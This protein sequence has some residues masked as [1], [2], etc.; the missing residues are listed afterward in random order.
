MNKK[1][2]SP[3]YQQSKS[4]PSWRTLKIDRWSWIPVQELVWYTPIRDGSC[5]PVLVQLVPWSR[6]TLYYI[7]RLIYGY[8]T[9]HYN[10][11][12]PPGISQSVNM[13]TS[14]N[15]KSVFSLR[16]FQ[17]HGLA[18]MCLKTSF[19]HFAKIWGFIPTNHNAAETAATVGFSSSGNAP[20]TG[21]L[22]SYR[23]NLCSQTQEGGDM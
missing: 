6:M 2:K 13:F 5:I 7:I 3:I 18:T 8:I 11:V 1:K 4:R 12:D 15:I 10:T 22:S 17:Y 9:L 21:F 20:V 19:V 23:L 14:S 16:K